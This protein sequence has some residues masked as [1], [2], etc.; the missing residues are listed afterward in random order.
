MADARDADDAHRAVLDAGF[1]Y[2]RSAG[3]VFVM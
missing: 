3:T 1:K 2:P